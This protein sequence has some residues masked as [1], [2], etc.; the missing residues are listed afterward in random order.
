MKYAM[1]AVLLVMFGCGADPGERGGQGIP[2]ETGAQGPAGTNA[3]AAVSTYTPSTTCASFGG[4][5][6]KKPSA[7]SS[8]VRLY[9][10]S[11]NCTANS[12]LL[13]TL[14][15]STK[16]VYSSGLYLYVVEGTG[17]ATKIRSYQFN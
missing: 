10:T 2:G 16:E 8:N 4:V 1:L 17:A 9:A 7:G 5:Y 11:A 13:T 12:S 6:G 14:N 3:T 15:S